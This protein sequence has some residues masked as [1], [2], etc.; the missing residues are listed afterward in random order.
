MCLAFLQRSVAYEQLVSLLGI[1]LGVGAPFPHIQKLAQ[2]G[3]SINYR[4]Y[5][6]LEEL[7]TLLLAGWPSIASVQTQDLPYWHGVNVYHVV[8]VVGM[9]AEH[10]HL[11]DPDLPAGPV[12][13]S[14]GDF[15]LAW[16]AQDETYAVIGTK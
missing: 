2:L 16:L 13:V 3:L 12:T 8:V 10:V 6:S 4:G 7:Y 14:L 9:D 15:D 1:Q 5:G 11:H